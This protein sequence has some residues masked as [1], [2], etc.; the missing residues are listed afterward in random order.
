MLLTI[1]CHF[2]DIYIL[3]SPK[4]I[5]LYSHSMRNVT[6]ENHNKYN[7]Q[8]DRYWVRSRS[9]S[10]LCARVNTIYFLPI[11]SWP[12]MF[13]QWIL[14]A[15]ISHDCVSQWVRTVMIDLLSTVGMQNREL[16]T[17]CQNI[18][19]A[20]WRTVHYTQGWK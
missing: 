13:E 20:G 11:D 10:Y 8:R 5:V 17:G 3:H 1:D 19:S 18:H 9:I 15:F 4:C 12:C 2:L 14:I 6:E 16:L 7:F